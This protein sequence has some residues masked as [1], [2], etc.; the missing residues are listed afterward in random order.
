MHPDPGVCIQTPA[1]QP[2]TIPH[3]AEKVC[4]LA[5]SW[6]QAL[7]AGG[8]GRWLEPLPYRVKFS[9]I[10][11]YNWSWLGWWQPVGG[12]CPIAEI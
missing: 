11:D 4:P 8:Q 3:L 1:L 5:A 2:E 6:L 9:S 7:E 12:R 10:Y